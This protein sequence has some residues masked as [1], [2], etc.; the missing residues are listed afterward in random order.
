MRG[1]NRKGMVLQ[2]RDIRL[3]K[4]LDPMRVI[5]REQAKVVA[6]F[7]STT[8]ANTRLLR[9]TRAG[10]LKR[11][12]IGTIGSGQKAI[13]TISGKGQALVEARLPGLPFRPTHNLVASPFLL[14]QL[15]IN[16]IYLTVKHRAISLENVRFRR[17]IAF[18]KSLSESLSLIPDGYCE[19]DVAGNVKAMF[20]EVDLGQEDS[21][22]WM[23]K[24]Q[25]YLQLALSGQFTQM[26][27]NPQFR[28]LIITSTER[29]ADNIRKTAAKLTDKIFWFAS[30][31][32]I[33]RDGFWSSIWLRPTG[34]Q[35]HPLF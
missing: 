31:E 6:G 27:R 34:D 25:R 35:R 22:I 2:P 3:L 29:R 33:H 8:R 13:Y 7:G 30:F 10:V 24:V 21:S 32:A 23:K 28:V 5:D 14:H 17:W 9:L 1:N 26:F 12:F 15:K 16:E 4:E 18:H 20:V 11:M 19:L